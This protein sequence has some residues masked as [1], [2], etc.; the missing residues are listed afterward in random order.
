MRRLL[1][2]LPLLFAAA[3]AFATG[4]F[5]C[6][7]TDGSGIELS[8]TVGRVVG[9]PIIAAALRIGESAWLTND[10]EPRIVIA[11]SWLDEEELKVDLADAQ[12]E[13]LEARLRTRVTRNGATGTIERDGR[14]HPV[15]CELE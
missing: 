2:A 15:R 3:P 12:V 1:I 10:A 8:G 9:N 14:R 13:R 5:D 6:R 11:R 4:G 7:T